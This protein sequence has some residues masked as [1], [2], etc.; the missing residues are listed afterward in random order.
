MLK[1]LCPAVALVL[2]LF[3]LSSRSVL[4]SRLRRFILTTACCRARPTQKRLPSIAILPPRQTIK[5]CDCH[6][7]AELM[8]S[9]PHLLSVVTL[10]LPLCVAALLLLTQSLSCRQIIA[11]LALRCGMSSYAASIFY[12]RAAHYRRALPLR[13]HYH[14]YTCPNTALC[15]SAALAPP[16]RRTSCATPTLSL[17]HPTIKCALA[18][19]SQS[20][21]CHRCAAPAVATLSLPTSAGKTWR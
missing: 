15:P 3:S 18:I 16:P 7:I 5:C 13:L 6:I 8:L 17:P 2:P 9:P 14:R 19:S 12:R 21:Y 4:P 10:V 1:S 11:A 20:L